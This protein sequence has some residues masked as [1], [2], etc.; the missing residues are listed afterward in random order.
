MLHCCVHLCLRGRESK[1]HGHLLL[2]V[3]Y[4]ERDSSKLHTYLVEHHHCWLLRYMADLNSL[5][6]TLFTFHLRV[7]LRN[8]VL[9]LASENIPCI[10]IICV[11]GKM[12][13]TCSKSEG[14]GQ[15]RHYFWSCTTNTSLCF[16]ESIRMC[17]TLW[18]MTFDFQRWINLNS[19]DAQPTSVKGKVLE[20]GSR[21]LDTTWSWQHKQISS[22]LS[23]KILASRS[24]LETFFPYHHFPSC[25]CR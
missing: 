5:M 17:F 21:D 23:P 13:T 14:M 18:N 20:A 8:V 12:L 9:D 10:F 25:F 11:L 6:H 15:L 3:W 19:E 16:I 24:Q 1:L 2:E 22:M 7:K 4:K